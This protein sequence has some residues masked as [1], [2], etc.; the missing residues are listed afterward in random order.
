MVTT[1]VPRNGRTC[2]A[3]VSSLRSIRSEQSKPRRVLRSVSYVPCSLSLN[4]FAVCEQLTIDY[5]GS[6][7]TDEKHNADRGLSLADTNTIT[8]IASVFHCE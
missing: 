3:L 2:L 7:E 1:H 4:S 6:S 5:V 8:F